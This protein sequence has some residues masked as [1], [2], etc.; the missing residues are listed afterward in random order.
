MGDSTGAATPDRPG[1]DRIAGGRACG[2]GPA[3]ALGKAGRLRLQEEVAETDVR[4]PREGG[5]VG[6]CAGKVAV[7]IVDEE[8][9]ALIIDDLRVRIARTDG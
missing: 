8:A 3:R 6:L 7:G 9:V 2:E 4:M 1:F 5:E